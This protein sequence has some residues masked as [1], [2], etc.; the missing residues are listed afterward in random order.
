MP[1]EPPNTCSSEGGVLLCENFIFPFR[2]VGVKVSAHIKTQEKKITCHNVTSCL[3][4]PTKSKIMNYAQ[5]EKDVEFPIATT[6]SVGDY[7]QSPDKGGSKYGR[8]V[9]VIANEHHVDHIC[10]EVTKDEAFG[11]DTKE[12]ES[13]TL[14]DG[15]KEWISGNIPEYDDV[16]YLGSIESIAEVA[17]NAAIKSNNKLSNIVTP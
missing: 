1:R 9:R 6:L 2:G 12:C 5:I 16:Q 10:V 7:V 17:W 11:D 8:V 15:F 14:N 3:T 4:L 13:P